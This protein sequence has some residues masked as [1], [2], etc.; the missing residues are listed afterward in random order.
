MCKLVVYPYAHPDFFRCLCRKL[1]M[2]IPNKI[3][4]TFAKSQL[5]EL[6]HL[7]FSGKI[8]QSSIAFLVRKVFFATLV[9]MV[10]C[11]LFL[12]NQ[13]ISVGINAT[14]NRNRKIKENKC[15]T[16]IRLL[17]QQTEHIRFIIC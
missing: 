15:T 13:H 8:D 10:L 2:L 12:I 17:F 16:R 3:H 7:K 14:K 9:D 11:C 4:A 6:L 5:R 1:D